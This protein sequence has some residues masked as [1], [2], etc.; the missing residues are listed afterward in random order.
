MK[1][2]K[3]MNPYWVAAGLMAIIFGAF[4]FWSLLIGDN[5]L[6]VPALMASLVSYAGMKAITVIEE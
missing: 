4:G 1:I 2:I 3:L 6:A 5:R